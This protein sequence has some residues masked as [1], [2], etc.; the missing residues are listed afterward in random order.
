ML[1]IINNTI[2]LCRGDDCAL[3]LALSKD[4]NAYTLQDGDKVE[5]STSWGWT[6]SAGYVG[7]D[8]ADVI[9]SSADTAK[10]DAGN[11]TY[12]ITLHYADRTQMALTVP[13]PMIIIEVAEDATDQPST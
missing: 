1:K 8:F 11:Y 6:T 9:I 12:T 7:D 2:C 13:Q 5:F 4:G 3:R 10:A